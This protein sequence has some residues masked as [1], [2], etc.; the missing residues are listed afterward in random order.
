LARPAFSSVS[1]QTVFQVILSLSLS[2]DPILLV[3]ILSFFPQLNIT[4]TLNKF[5]LFPFVGDH[6]P[7]V[8]DNY[9]ATTVYEGHAVKLGL[10]DTSGKY[11][12]ITSPHFV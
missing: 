4:N 3:Q 7:T 9:T 5:V 11:T 8:F 1:Q 10:W 6:V 12:S 2:H